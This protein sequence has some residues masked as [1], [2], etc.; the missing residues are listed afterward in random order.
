MPSLDNLTLDE[1]KPIE[2][3][4][5]FVFS[6]DPSKTRKDLLKKEGCK[7]VFRITLIIMIL[8]IIPA[9]LM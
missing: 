7:T 6:G 1:L 2:N 9:V 3:S 8:S 4:G 5:L